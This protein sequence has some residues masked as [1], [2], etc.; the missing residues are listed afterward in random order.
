MAG[1]EVVRT[2]GTTAIVGQ[3]GPCRGEGWRRR[4]LSTVSDSLFPGTME[5]A[6]GEA[7]E[8][9]AKEDYSQ[10]QTRIGQ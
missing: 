6:A 7:R 9:T 4:E 2:C 5:T 3:G 10:R 1:L 8:A